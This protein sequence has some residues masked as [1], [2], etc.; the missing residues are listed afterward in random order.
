MG[1]VLGAVWL[2]NIILSFLFS[3]MIDS[4]L[5]KEWTFGV[6]AILNAFVTVYILFL[7]ET[8]GLTPI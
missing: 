6:Y 7:K 3:Y 5:G 1:V 8:K 2:S 4:A